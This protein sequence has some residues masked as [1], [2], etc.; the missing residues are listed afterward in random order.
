M[1]I[2]GWATAT[3]LF[4]EPIHNLWLCIG[5]AW[6]FN[7]LFGW[8]AS[9]VVQHEQF[10]HKKA[11]GT[12]KEVSIYLFITALLFFLGETMKDRNSVLFSL[13]VI[14][15]A[16]ILFYL[17]NILKNLRRLAPDSKGVHYVYIL[18]SLEFLKNLP[19]FKQFKKEEKDKLDY[20]GTNI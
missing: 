10:N 18:V 2:I 19:H 4:F 8:V 16:F 5:V 1:L 9:M 13:N 15:W 12:M 14:T 3:F 7:F 20:D 17:I 6:L 11:L